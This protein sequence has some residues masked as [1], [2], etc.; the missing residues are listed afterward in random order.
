MSDKVD[1]HTKKLKYKNKAKV[2][3]IKDPTKKQ[4]KKQGFKN[5]DT[6]SFNNIDIDYLEELFEDE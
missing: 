6:R 2:T 5:F 3:K 1:R 4:R